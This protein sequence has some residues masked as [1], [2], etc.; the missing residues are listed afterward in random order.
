MKMLKKVVLKSDGDAKSSL[1]WK[2]VENAY[3]LVTGVLMLFYR[4]GCLRE[5]RHFFIR[6]PAEIKRLV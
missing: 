6:H 4:N 2:N 1:C 3:S 5:G